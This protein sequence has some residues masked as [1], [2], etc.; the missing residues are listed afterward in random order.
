MRVQLQWL[1]MFR[2]LPD[3]CAYLHK[4]ERHLREQIILLVTVYQLIGPSKFS[5]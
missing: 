3:F 5:G 1:I 4:Q 2:T